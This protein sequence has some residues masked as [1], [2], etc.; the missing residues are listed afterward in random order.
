MTS[1]QL[2]SLITGRPQPGNL[3][4]SFRSQIAGCRITEPSEINALAAQLKD[5][6]PFDIEPQIRE[7][8][9]RSRARVEQPATPDLTT[10]T[11]RVSKAEAEPAPRFRPCACGCGAMRYCNTAE[12]EAGEELTGGQH[13]QHDP[14]TV[15]AAAQRAYCERL[16]RKRTMIEEKNTEAA[17]PKAPA[18]P[19]DYKRLY[20]LAAP[21]ELPEAPPPEPAWKPLPMPLKFKVSKTQ[22]APSLAALAG[23]ETPAPPPPPPAFAAR[24]PQPL[25]PE[26]FSSLA[27]LRCHVVKA[28]FTSAA[29]SPSGG[30]LMR[31]ASEPVLARPRRRPTMEMQRRYTEQHLY[32][33]PRA[34]PG[35]LAALEAR[36]EELRQENQEAHKE[37]EREQERRRRRDLRRAAKRAAAI[38]DEAPLGW[39]AEQDYAKSPT[40]TETGEPRPRE[41]ALC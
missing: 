19:P 13:L 2:Q 12:D 27:E 11:S 38:Q 18:R 41:W 3:A 30:S 25:S 29:V 9:R 24:A 31:D 17:I 32:S 7:M 20:K 6:M 10:T 39:D 23:D 16:S 4:A 1:A 8:F 34:K 35:S 15:D 22:S 40:M 14:P 5:R 21:R 33:K 36:L 37:Q 28:S 26:G